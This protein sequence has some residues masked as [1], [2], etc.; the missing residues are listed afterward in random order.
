M[1]KKDNIEEIIKLHINEHKSF[2]ELVQRYA[3]NL[4]SSGSANILE[5]GSGTAI[6][7]YYISDKT[8]AN[9]LAT[10]ISGRAIEVAESRKSSG[11]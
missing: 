11:T 2:F 3:E 1:L 4:R 9:V 8:Q 7:S 6:D 10:D 5:I